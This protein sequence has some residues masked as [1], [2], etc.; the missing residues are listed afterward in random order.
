[1]GTNFY[2]MC[3][4]KKLV[5]ENFANKTEWSIMDEEYSI[6]DEP[7][8]GYEIHLNKLSYAWR[9]LFQRHKAFKKF[10]ELEQFYYAH[11]ADLEIFDKYQD[12]YTWE[13]YFDRVQNHSLREKEPAKWVYEVDPLFG[14]TK[15]NLHIVM[16]TEEEADLF[17]P[18]DHLIYSKTEKEARLKLK[19]CE[20]YHMGL[21]YWNDSDYLFDWTE[22]EFS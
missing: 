3:R 12:K 15:P 9:P 16:C 14:G 19:V 1:M 13:E 10:K 20:P 11:K 7:Y 8:L 5:Q 4:N 2:F 22:G 6:V 21:K 17:V 18:F